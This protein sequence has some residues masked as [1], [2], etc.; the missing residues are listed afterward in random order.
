MTQ[1]EKEDDYYQNF[2]FFINVIKFGVN[3][4]NLD[5]RKH[6]APIV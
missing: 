2:D 5:D 1:E 4:K 6:K 3:P